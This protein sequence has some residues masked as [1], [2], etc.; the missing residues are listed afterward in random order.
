MDYN[1][2]ETIIIKGEECP[3]DP[4]SHIAQVLC[5]SCSQ[6]NEIEVYVE[7]GEAQF[8]GFVCEKCGAWN[9]V[10]G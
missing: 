1:F 8:M 4:V 9:G 10:E 2:T 5:N 6:T 7:N 3:Y